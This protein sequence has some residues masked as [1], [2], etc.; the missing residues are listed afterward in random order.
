MFEEFSLM[1][2]FKIG[3]PVEE[4]V[5][6][7][8]DFLMKYRKSMREDIRDRWDLML[9]EDVERLRNGMMN[10]GEWL[11]SRA[12]KLGERIKEAREK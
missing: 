6:K 5:I 7:L 11:E 3:I 2:Q 1:A 9:L 10:A 4:L 12:D 8:L